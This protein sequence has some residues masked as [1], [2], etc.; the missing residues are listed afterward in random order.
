MTTPRTKNQDR[1]RSGVS[2]R[3][4]VATG[5]TLLTGG[6]VDAV[7]SVIGEDCVSGFSVDADRFDPDN[8]RQKQTPDG[9]FT[10]VG[11]SAQPVAA[12]TGSITADRMRTKPSSNE[13]NHHTPGRPEPRHLSLP[14]VYAPPWPDSIRRRNASSRSL[15]A[16]GVTPATRS[17]PTSAGSVATAASA[18]R[19][20]RVAARDSSPYE[21]FHGLGVCSLAETTARCPQPTKYQYTVIM[22]VEV[23]DTRYWT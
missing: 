13:R 19:P 5:V 7:Q 22:P 18:P 16:C 11:K 9:C 21:P 23:R 15:S 6:R 8:Q 14:P 17:A 20:A 4:V 1:D 12:S 2:R 3:T 10:R